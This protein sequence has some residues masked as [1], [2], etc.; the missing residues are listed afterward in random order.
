[1]R[2]PADKVSKKAECRHYWVM[3]VFALAAGMV[4]PVTAAGLAAAGLPGMEVGEVAGVV[5]ELL[6]YNR[7]VPGSQRYRGR[8]SKERIA[9]SSSCQPAAT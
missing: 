1:M 7:P 8:L 4:C 3:A 5:P 2:V 9:S 6:R